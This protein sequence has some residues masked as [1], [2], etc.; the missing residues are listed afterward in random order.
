MKV[1]SKGLGKI[2]LV[3]DFEK[4]W[5]E[6]EKGENGDTLYIK[7]TITDPVVW[8]FKITM[9]E[10]DIPGLMKIALDKEIITMFLKNPK[11][12]IASTFKYVATQLGLKKGEQ[13]DKQIESGEKNSA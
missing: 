2:E 1:W 3:L 13:S 9:T 6:R 8:D 11:A 10:E 5:V 12:S 4:Y 7:G